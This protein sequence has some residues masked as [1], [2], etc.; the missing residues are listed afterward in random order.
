MMPESW[1]SPL[2]DNGLLKRISA[3]RDMLA[4]VKVLPW[5]DTHFCGK[6]Y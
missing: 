4:E 6:E 3:A 1:S 2:P 5:I